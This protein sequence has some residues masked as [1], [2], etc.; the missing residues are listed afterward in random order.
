MNITIDTNQSTQIQ[1]V[2]SL[3][4][5][6]EFGLFL[7]K[8]VSSIKMA[9]WYT[10]DYNI[11]K[12]LGNLYD[13]LNNL[14]DKMQE[15]IIGT[16]KTSNVFFPKLNLIVDNIE[17]LENYQDDQKIIN[18]FDQTKTVLKNLL[19]SL[20]FIQYVDTVQSGINNTKEEIISELNKT[21]YL[22]S[23]IKL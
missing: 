2:N 19:C 4:T 8:I 7:N 17:S 5:T 12:I 14:F 22:L 18:V 21:E 15:E 11:H 16:S 6:R 9:H 23:M 3:D 20:E 13:N 1:I 10:Q